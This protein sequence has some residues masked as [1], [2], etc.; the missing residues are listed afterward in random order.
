[1]KVKKY[2]KVCGGRKPLFA[3]TKRKMKQKNI[4]AKQGAPSS[5]NQG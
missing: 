2:N 1:M 3:T 5:N 4:S